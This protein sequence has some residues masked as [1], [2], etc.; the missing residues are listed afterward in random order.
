[1]I[2][3]LCPTFRRLTLQIYDYKMLS[4]N[5]FAQFLLGLL[6][7]LLVIATKTKKLSHSCRKN[8]SST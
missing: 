7:H 5:R 8:G 2:F 6:R 3:L 1:M 4:S